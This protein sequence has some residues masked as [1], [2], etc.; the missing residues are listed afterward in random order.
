MLEKFAKNKHSNFLAISKLK[1][2]K[3]CEYDPRLANGEIFLL[4]KM[5]HSKLVP[6][7][8]TCSPY[9][10]ELL[11]FDLGKFFRLV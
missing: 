10:K 7:E 1:K 2:M 3:C 8:A 4:V 6:N 11:G 9:T 5:V